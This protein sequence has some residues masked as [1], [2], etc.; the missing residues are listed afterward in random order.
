MIWSPRLAIFDALARGE[1]EAA[2]QDF[3][4]QG[5][6]V[7]A[8]YAQR[9]H[10]SAALRA[11]LD[12]LDERLRVRDGKAPPEIIG[13]TPAPAAP[14]ARSPARKAPRRPA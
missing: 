5:M 2:L 6:W 8:A 14:P 1:L 12:F 10:N 3:S 7:Y 4:I 13:L 9:H 11:L